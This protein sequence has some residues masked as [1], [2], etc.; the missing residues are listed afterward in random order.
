[1]VIKAGELAC[2]DVAISG[3]DIGMLIR[4]VSDSAVVVTLTGASFRDLANFAIDLEGD[5]KL[6]VFATDFGD[7]PVDKRIQALGDDA[8][9]TVHL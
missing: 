2:K 3:S 7:I 9:V 4:S 1:M 6:D 8:K 5:V